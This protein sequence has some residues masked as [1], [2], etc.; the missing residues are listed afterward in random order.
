MISDHASSSLSPSPALP[1][2]N[3]RRGRQTDRQADRE[4]GE[5]KEGASI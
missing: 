1:V 5:K 3:E 4:A 2:N